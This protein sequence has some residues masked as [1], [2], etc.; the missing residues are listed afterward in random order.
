MWPLWLL[1]VVV[2]AVFSGISVAFSIYIS[3]IIDHAEPSQSSLFGKMVLLGAGVLICMLVGCVL[4]MVGEKYVK[5]KILN[6]IRNRLFKQI[7]A[8]KI[9]RYESKNSSEY[10]SQLTNDVNILLENYVQPM[11]DLVGGVVNIVAATVMILYYAPIALLIILICTLAIMFVPAMMGNILQ[12]KQEIFSKQSA[13][14]TNRTKDL[15]MGYEVIVSSGK[16]TQ[17]VGEYVDEND[18]YTKKQF[19]ADGWVAANQAVSQML[20]MGIQTAVTLSCVWYMMQGR[21]SAGV[22][23]MVVQLMNMLVY[24][25]IGLISSI[26]Q[27][28]GAKPVFESMDAYLIEDEPEAN[29]AF[30]DS[31]ALNHL[32]FAYESANADGNA[33]ADAISGAAGDGAG[34]KSG[35][36]DESKKENILKDINF[37]FEKGKKYAI[38]GPSGC[39]KS[40]LLKILSGYYENYD[41]EIMLD[42]KKVDH[43]SIGGMMNLT[44]F[45]QQNVFLFDKSIREN[46]CMY[47]KADDQELASVLE[48]SGVKKFLG[49]TIALDDPVGENGDRLSGG[50]KQRIAIARAYFQKKNLVLMD[51]GTSALDAETAYEIERDLLDDD[52]VTLVTVTH[53]PNEELMRRYDCVI[54][55]EQGRI[56][57]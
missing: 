15:L 48:R 55:M 37:T 22:L 44:A 49:E 42:G 3:W 40:T 36:S 41:G 39:G 32:E 51:E 5:N 45:I 27:M 10:L 46:I 53:H 52:A 50:Q 11:L 35:H 57:A 14:F 1:L 6:M 23:M 16:R 4:F 29:L 21:M 38:V 9:A 47:Q 17:A 34:D 26:S 28:K 33:D 2:S 24:P 54:H 18:Q 8:Q 30:N 43:A 20:G 25:I 56:V 7:Y 12:K 19:G 13:V 31:I